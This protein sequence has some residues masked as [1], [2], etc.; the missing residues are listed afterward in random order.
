[1]RRRTIVQKLKEEL[2]LPVRS[3]NELTLRETALHRDVS[4]QLGQ[5]AATSL[6]CVLLDGA[7]RF[8]G[9]SDLETSLIRDLAKIHSV[10]LSI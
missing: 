6:E 5:V 4:I 8:H 9:L 2:T 3:T 10:E 1:M 7:K